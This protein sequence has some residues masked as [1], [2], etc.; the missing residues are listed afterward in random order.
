LHSLFR[1]N[2]AGTDV[3]ASS[4]YKEVMVYYICNRLKGKLFL[5]FIRTHHETPAKFSELSK[6]TK[7]ALYTY[8]Y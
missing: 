4:R 3:P 1:M 6:D 2:D 5:E 8:F 7:T